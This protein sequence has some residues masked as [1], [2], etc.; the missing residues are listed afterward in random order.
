MHIYAFT[1][2]WKYDPRTQVMLSMVVHACNPSVWELEVGG[3]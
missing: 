2:S 3:F 1:H